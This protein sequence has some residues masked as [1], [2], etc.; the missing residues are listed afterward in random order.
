MSCGSSRLVR[1]DG[2]PVPFL[3]TPFDVLQAPFSPDSKWVA[4][5]SNESGRQEIYVQSFPAGGAKWL[6]SSGGGILARWRSDGKELFYRGLD[7]KLIVAS[8]RS[9]PGGLE[10][11]TPTALF[12]TSEPQG[13]FSYPYDV[14]SDGQRVLLHSSL[15]R[16]PETPPP[17][18]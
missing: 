18:P 6:V 11:G 17:C 16:L 1:G 5:T 14:S 7:G 4:Y 12:I 9:A 8:V 13:Q 10:F 2:K 3:R 15:A